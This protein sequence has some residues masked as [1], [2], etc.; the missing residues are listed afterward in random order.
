MGRRENV[1]THKTPG[2]EEDKR[3]RAEQYEQWEAKKAEKP[4][5]PSKEEITRRMVENTSAEGN[6]GETAKRIL[7][8]EY[9]LKQKRQKYY[10]HVE[11]TAQYKQALSDRGKPQSTISIS[12][13]ETQQAIYD[14]AG[15]GIS[16]K[17]RD[18]TIS[19]VEYHMYHKTIGT[20]SENNHT[21]ET[22]RFAIHY[23]KSGSH[24]VPVKEVEEDD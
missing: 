22:R 11:G 3:I 13:H 2:S 18:G 14:Y 21:I 16:R 15:K 24:I 4:K 20:Y 17:K 10:Q 8:G 23:G 12:E 7:S 19:N 6:Q 5:H 9:S 1:W